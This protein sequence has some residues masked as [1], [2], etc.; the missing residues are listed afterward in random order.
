MLPVPFFANQLDKLDSF[1]INVKYVVLL[2]LLNESEVK[3]S[4]EVLRFICY[5]Y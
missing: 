3:V 2:I 5:C 4:E 1:L